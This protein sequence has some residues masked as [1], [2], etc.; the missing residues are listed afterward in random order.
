MSGGIKLISIEGAV[1][2]AVMIFALHDKD[3]VV[4]W[5]LTCPNGMEHWGVV[6]RYTDKF[7]DCFSQEQALDLFDQCCERYRNE[8]EG[9]M[10]PS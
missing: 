5:K 8:V 2:E 4:L 10:F 1:A 3:L 9:G 6:N 7:C